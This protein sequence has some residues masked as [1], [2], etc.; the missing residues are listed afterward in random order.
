MN[1]GNKSITRSKNKNKRKYDILI[2]L[3]PG[4]PTEKCQF[5]EIEHDAIYDSRVYIGGEVRMQAAVKASKEAEWIILVGGSQKKVTC[6]KEYILMRLENIEKKRL[7]KRIIRI[8]SSPDTNG[9][10]HAV[11]MA[12]SKL[13]RYTERLWFL[14]NSYHIARTKLFAGEIFN[15]KFDKDRF[16]EAEKLDKKSLNCCCLTLEKNLREEL[17]KQGCLNWGD[18]IYRDQHKNTE[19]F[20]CVI[21]DLKPYEE[22]QNIISRI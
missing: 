8:E 10:M 1:K 2:V 15:F 9:N 14:T 18:R 13:N 22:F 19:K 5:P 4:N 17:E 21:H 20:N 7:K 16:L 11:K 3:C 6:M 12:L